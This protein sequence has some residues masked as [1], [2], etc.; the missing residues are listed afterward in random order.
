MNFL[1]KHS[2]LILFALSTSCADMGCMKQYDPQGYWDTLKQE[3]KISHDGEATLTED[4]EL[5]KEL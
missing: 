2:V 1:K 4:G 3:E 5:K